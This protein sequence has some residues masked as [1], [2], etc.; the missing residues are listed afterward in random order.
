MTAVGRAGPGHDELDGM[1][2]RLFANDVDIMADPSPIWH[3]LHDYGRAYP[4]RGGVLVSSHSSTR[5]VL[6]DQDRFSAMWSYRGSFIAR[7][8][9]ELSPSQMEAFDELQRFK[10]Y[11]MRHNDDP[12]HARIRKLVKGA[13]SPRQIARLKDRT[14]A[15]VDAQIDAWRDHDVIDLAEFAYGLPL[16]VICEMLGVPPEDEAVVHTWSGEFVGGLRAQ[17]AEMVIPARD[18][19]RSWKAYTIETLSSAAASG[20]ESGL[21]QD[22]L[23]ARRAGELD[24]EGAAAICINMLGAGHETSANLIG[25]GVYELLRRPDEWRALCADRGLVASAV[26]ELLRMVTPTQWEKRVALVDMVVDG[27]DVSAEQTVFPML[28]AANRDPEVFTDPD[29]THVA[30]PNARDHLAF[31]FGPHVCIGAGLSR[32]EAVVALE[33]LARRVPDMELVTDEVEWE[34]I[35]DLR[36]IKQVP[37]RCGVIARAS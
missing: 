2:D 3:M 33:G 35:A 1:L 11:F 36:R 5:A 6:R 17:G 15:Y 10:T 29:E 37:V 25:T 24:D 18:A 16:R 8:L 34:G 23:D 7:F 4:Y 22:L 14:Q 9:A 20:E 12:E 21:L 31:G 32:L 26:E 19:I 13:F 27:T 28:A 30:R